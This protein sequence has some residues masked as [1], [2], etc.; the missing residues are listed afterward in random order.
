M[1][2]KSHIKKKLKICVTPPASQTLAAYQALTWKEVKGMVALPNP[3]FNHNMISV[4]DIGTGVTMQIKG[5]Q[6]G[7]AA[8]GAYYDI[9]GDEGQAEVVIANS[10]LDDCAICIV[11]A[12]GAE[13]DF[14]TGPLGSLAATEGSDTTH[15]GQTFQFTPNY[16]KVRGAAVSGG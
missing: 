10:Q 6:T 2:P 9:E 5:S 8:S 1:A 14:W 7:Q 3:S 12:D 13:A 15:A 4:P 16:P 11:D